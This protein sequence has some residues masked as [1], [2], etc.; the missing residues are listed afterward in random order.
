MSNLQ[1]PSK[2]SPS[3]L[4]RTE[5]ILEKLF[6]SRT[7][8]CCTIEPKL[9]E[10]EGKQIKQSPKNLI[11]NHNNNNNNNN[12]NGRKEPPLTS[13]STANDSLKSSSFRVWL[14]ETTIIVRGPSIFSHRN[15]LTGSIEMQSAFFFS[16]N[17]SKKKIER[18]KGGKEEE[19]GGGR[20][21]KIFTAIYQKSLFS[22]SDVP[23]LLF[24]SVPIVEVMD[25]KE[26]KWNWKMS[27]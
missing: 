25:W 14:N 7:C 12:A 23:P 11:N 13:E 2:W 4:K 8:N 26:G 20:I 19:G 1:Q 17:L 16:Y 3:P 27:F 9:A 10:Q 22:F 5:T 24:F 6:I 18:E 15:F 21:R